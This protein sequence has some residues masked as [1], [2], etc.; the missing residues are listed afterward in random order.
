MLSAVRTEE[1]VAWLTV[2]ERPESVR[3]VVM[4]GEGELGEDCLDSAAAAAA[5]EEEEE[6]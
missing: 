1:V 5:A 2:I 3:V 4:V 6:E